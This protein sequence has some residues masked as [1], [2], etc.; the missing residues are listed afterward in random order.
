[1]RSKMFL[2]S[3][4]GRLTRCGVHGADWC[5]VDQARQDR[6]MD[7]V[8]GTNPVATLLYVIHGRFG[9]RSRTLNALKLSQTAL[10]G[11]AA[12]NHPNVP[13]PKCFGGKS[14]SRTA[15]G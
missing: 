8:Q 10:P 7:L 14:P 13:S 5:E 15:S 6:I 11:T 3:R 4:D 9:P 2:A 1:M 12:K